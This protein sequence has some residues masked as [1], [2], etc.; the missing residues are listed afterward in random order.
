MKTIKNTLAIIS[1]SL[2][3]LSAQASD[4]TYNPKVADILATSLRFPDATVDAKQSVAIKSNDFKNLYFV[5]A[6]VNSES[7]GSNIGVWI[8]NSLE[9]GMIFSAN[10]DAAI[11][12]VFPD[13]QKSGPKVKTS[14]HGYNEAIACFKKKY[15]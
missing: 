1:L 3:S 7:F 4:C 2:T 14:D 15:K 6:R 11:T 9:S 8:S 10:S 5:A 13:G 12:T